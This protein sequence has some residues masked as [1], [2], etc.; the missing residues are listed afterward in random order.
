MLLEGE[1]HMSNPIEDAKKLYTYAYPVVISS[2]L[3]R[4]KRERFLQL[5]HG[6][7]FVSAK[8]DFP[9]VRPNNDTLYSTVWTH[10][11]ESPYILEIPEITGRYLL[12][13]FLNSKTDIPFAVGSKN[14]GKEVGKYI[15]LYREEPVPA[16]YEDYQVVR[17]E[18][19]RNFFIVRLESFGK[20]DY[21]T[22]NRLQDQII[23]RPLYPEKITDDGEQITGLST[24]YL[25]SLSLQEF[26]AI[27]AQSYTDTFIQPEYTE[28]FKSFGLDPA[29]FAYDA[30]SEEAKTALEE[31]AKLAEVEIRAHENPEKFFSNEWSTTVKDLGFY[32][33]NYDLRATVAYYGYG[34]NLA[35]DS[36]YPA[37]E[38][39][40]D[41]NPL[42]SSNSYRVHFEKDGLPRAEFFW[43]LTLYGLPSQF[44]ADNVLDRYLI[45]SHMLKDLVFNE[46][47]S[48]DIYISQEPPA[49]EKL[50]P[51]WLPSSKTEEKFSLTL[52]IYGPDAFTLQGNWVAPKVI[53]L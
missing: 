39:D 47:G 36:V 38:H 26:Y 21:E 10:L 32:G 40:Q 51:N 3:S 23:I 28:L 29:Q 33:T 12:V 25:E 20:E 19:S 2:V 43:S 35:E 9:I 18:D 50:L 45:N 24:I 34:A 30:I 4:G 37:T 53:R 46:D 17:S 13:D 48:L 27:F 49:D 52:R 14:K 16:G 1:C 15:I 22:A 11:A 41:G 5:S 44:L 6:R 7:K 31:G 8:D 42:F